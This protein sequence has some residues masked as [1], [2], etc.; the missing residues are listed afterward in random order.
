MSVATA[1]AIFPLIPKAL[2][3]PTPDDLRAANQ[4]LTAE[5]LSHIETLRDL[6]TAK[7]ALQSRVA[8]QEQ[9]LSRTQ[10]ILAAVSETTPTFIYAKDNQGALVYV[11]A[12]V[13]QALGRTLEQVIGKTDADFL[14]DRGQ[15]E[16]IMANDRRI[17]ETK[18]SE[19]LEEK[20]DT[21][22][23]TQRT[24]VSTKTP[25]ISPAGD[26]IGLI[27]VSIDVTDRKSLE[28]ELSASEERL[29]LGSEAA[30]FGTYEFYPATGQLMLSDQLRDLFGADAGEET[31]KAWFLAQIH[32]DDRQK[33]PMFLG[34]QLA[35]DARYEQEYRV[36]LK[37]GGVRW[38]L[39]R[40]AARA[41]ATG[42]SAIE[43]VT[44][45]VVDITDRKLA[46]QRLALLMSE[47]A[48]RGKNQIAVIQSIANRSLTGNRTLDEG[49]EIFQNRLLAISRSMS[50]LSLNSVHSADLAAIVKAELESVLDR[51]DISGPTIPLRSRPAQNFSLLVHELATNAIKYGALSVPGG[52]VDVSWTL[53]GTKLRFDWRERGGPPASPPTRKGFGTVIIAHNIAAEFQTD[54]EI[55]YGPTG[56][57]YGFDVG[58]ALIAAEPD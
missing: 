7:G 29:R 3:I 37:S 8:S 42:N 19:T 15:A 13:L 26:T 50:N 58:L 51:V 21:P 46:E 28:A 25:H 39:D 32:P 1:L 45:A 43:R 52:R 22:D 54:V 4:R 36:I 30:R 12:A 16:A 38:L 18:T 5:V 14:V 53:R 48:H 56:L 2:A 17:R 57:V 6:E 20:I 49:R 27:G 11:N 31:G 35:A 40:C 33:V 55:D 44:G 23:G 24:F 41:S 9:E 34:D 10:A 47:L